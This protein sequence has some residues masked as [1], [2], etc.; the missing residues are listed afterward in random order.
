M[1]FV[2]KVKKGDTLNTI[3]Q[4]HGFKNYKEAGVSA[5]P[6]GNF[7]LIR[8]GEDITLGNYNPNKISTIGSTPPVLSSKDNQQEYR[9]NSSKIDGMLTGLAGKAD[10]STTPKEETTKETITPFSTG[11]KTTDGKIET[12]GD[13]VL[14]KINAWT[15]EQSAKFDA[16]A[17]AKK[18][19]YSQLYNTSLAAIDATTKSTIDYINTT[20]DKRLA[21]QKRINQINIDRVQA[22]GLGNGGQYTPI[23]FSDAVTNRETEA[24]DRIS[25]LEGER[26]SLIAEAKSARDVGS[27]K[28]LREKLADL[29]KIDTDIRTQLQNV[30]KEADD[31]YKLLRDYRK[32]EE[33]KIKTKRE[34]MLKRLQALAPKYSDEFDK[35]DESAKDELIKKIATQTGLEYA[36]VYSTLQSAVTTGA[37]AKTD[38]EKAL[39]DIDAAKALATQRRAA[40]AKSL[41]DNK[42]E[43]DFTPTELKKLEQAGLSGVTRQ[44]Q[45]DF[46]Y[47]DEYDE[48]NYGDN[49]GGN[50]EETKAKS[51]KIGETVTIGG[52]KYVKKGADDYVPVK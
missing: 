7:D 3:A 22:Y 16:D 25:S 46:L 12:T 24:A 30:K 32:E 44:Q 5:V 42:G 40:A 1:P 17:L 41:K 37:K 9:D 39:V 34:E 31:Q 6:S 11:E 2:Y 51:A 4:Q 23:A 29:D 21:E 8:E 48:A 35:L 36:Y 45:L 27:S 15:K 49:K 18:E 52:K 19:S 50:D 47:D 33:A 14:D 28:L 38:K 26:N 13:P 20:Y 43:T 10:S